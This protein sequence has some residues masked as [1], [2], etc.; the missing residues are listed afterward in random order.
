MSSRSTLKAVKRVSRPQVLQIELQL[1]GRRWHQKE[2]NTSKYGKPLRNKV[3]KLAAIHS[4][5]IL[6]Y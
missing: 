1:W 4:M 6:N 5:A 3:R 2:K